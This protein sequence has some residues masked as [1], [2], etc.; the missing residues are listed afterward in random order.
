MARAT[1]DRHTLG[2][3]LAG[4]ALVARM[5]GNHDESAKLFNETLLVS[6]ELGDQWIMPRA[7]G[8]LAGAAVLAANYDRAARL[9]GVTAAM[10]DVSGIGEAA[11]TFRV[12]YE[13]DEGE[14][15]TALGDEV[16][17]AAWAEGKTMTL[18]QAIAY[19][20]EDAALLCTP[21]HS[22]D[23]APFVSEHDNLSS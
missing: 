21:K 4:L 18:E 19:A 8:G 14:A 10:R 16:F 17:A 13:R 3:A 6:S 23:S 5:Q 9:F 7:L 22:E 15:R 11:Q 12:V 1:R 2:L 20:L